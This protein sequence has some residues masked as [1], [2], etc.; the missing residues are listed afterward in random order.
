MPFVPD[1]ACGAPKN[2]LRRTADHSGDK[3]NPPKVPQNTPKTRFFGPFGPYFLFFGPAG[4]YFLFCGPCGA[5]ISIFRALRGL[6]PNFS[7]PAMLLAPFFRALRGVGQ[8]P[9]QPECTC[10]SWPSWPQIQEKKE[11]N[12]N[13]KGN[14]AL[15]EPEKNPVAVFF[16]TGLRH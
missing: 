6:L 15:P 11:S 16:F 14:P 8:G 1:R 2:R 5:F 9:R 3:K 12:K 7:G 13:K 10:T 4:P